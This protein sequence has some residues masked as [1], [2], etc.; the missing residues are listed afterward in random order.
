MNGIFIDSVTLF[1]YHEVAHIILGHTATSGI[2]WVTSISQ[3]KEA[4]E[5]A[6]EMYLSERSSKLEKLTAGLSALFTFF[7]PFFV[8][9]FPRHLQ[10]ETHPDIDLRFQNAL[11]KIG[12]EGNEERYSLY[13]LAVTLINDYLR[14]HEQAL[15]HHGLEIPKRHVETVQDLYDDYI[16][17]LEQAKFKGI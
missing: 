10:Q 14:S 4:D 7:S 6:F 8:L 1:L 13:K 12:C 17:V 5:Y 9:V 2:D 15:I 11:E 3:E 16:A